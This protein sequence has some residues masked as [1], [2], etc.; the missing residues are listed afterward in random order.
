MAVAC[1]S[2]GAPADADARFCSRCGRTLAAGVATERRAIVTV[3]FCDLVEST[4]LGER[5]DPELLRE[6]QAQYFSACSVALQRHGGQIEK[7]I[8]DAVLCV[9]GLPRVRED[10]ALRACRAALDLRNG[11]AELDDRLVAEWSVGLDVRIGI[12]TGEVVTGDL[13]RDQVLATGDAV[14]V[15]ARLEQAAGPGEI[16]LGAETHRLVA[17]RVVVDAVP[18]FPAKG[19]SEPVRAYR[20]HALRD[21]APDV[22][23]AGPFVG[24]A[25][26]LAR[27]E[28]ALAAATASRAARGLLLV[29][30]PGI[31]KTRL[32]AELA[33]TAPPEVTFVR[34]TCLPY[35]EG[36]T[37]WPLREILDQVDRRGV[38]VSD[39]LLR[40]VGRRPGPVSRDETFDA[41]VRLFEALAADRP[42]VA[43]FED[44][45]WAEPL[46]LELLDVLPGALAESPVVVVGTARPELAVRGA[47]EALEPLRLDALDA[48]DAAA[49]AEAHGLDPARRGPVVGAA[50]GNPLFLEQ[51]CAAGLT[52][53]LP[54]DLRALLDARLGSLGE[55]ERELVEVAAVVGRDFWI[56]ALQALV[57]E[58]AVADLVVSLRTLERLELVEEAGTT[59]GGPPT[60]LSNVFT[61]SGRWSFRHTL[62]Q[63]AAYRALTKTRRSTLHAR[64]A[65][66]LDESAGDVPGLDAVVAWHLEQAAHL[67]AELRPAD[68][69]ELAARAAA[70]LEDA[71][72]QA[73]ERDD[74]RAAAG[75]LSRAASLAVDR[76]DGT[77]PVEPSL[78]QGERIA[79]YVVETVAGRGGMGVVYRAR[80]E[81]LGR[82]V[83]LKVISP[84]FARDAG[85]RSRFKRESLIAAQ[86]EHPN[87]VPV[88]TAGEHGERLY[89]AMRYVVGTDLASLIEREGRLDPET[90]A[91]I[92]DQVAHALDAAHVRGLVHRD[93]KP[94]NVLL[95]RDGPRWRAFLT[96]FG[97]SVQDGG[98][99]TL[100]RT[101]QWVG[102][103]AYVA[104]EQVRGS[105]VDGRADVYALGGVLHHCLTGEV[106][107]PRTHEL[108]ALSAHLAEPPPRPSSIVPDLLPFDDV[109]AR[110][111]AKEPSRR[112][113]TAVELGRA[114]LAASHAD[115]RRAFAG[116]AMRRLRARR[117][118][119]TVAGAATLL[120]AAAIAV[121]AIAIVGTGGSP[122]ARTPARIQV[123]QEPDSLAV[124]GDQVWALT[125]NGGRLARIDPATGRVGSFPAPVDLGGLAYPDIESGFG[126]IWIAH[127]N[128][129]VGGVD[130]INPVTVQA[131]QHIPLPGATAIA[132]GRHDV[133][134]IGHA[135]PGQSAFVLARIDPQ[136]NRIVHSLR[137]GAQP[138]AVA[139]G[140]GAVWVADARRDAVYRVDAGGTRRVATIP[141]GAGPGRIVAGSGAVWVANLGDQTLS[142]I[143]PSTNRVIGAPV[144]LGKEIDDIALAGS[145]LWVASA[146]ATVVGLRAADGTVVTPP[147]STDA[148]PLALA[149]DGANVWVASVAADTVARVAPR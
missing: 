126:S 92:V 131:E 16:L 57:P 26:D 18:P 94:G 102:T 137:L 147:V 40:A 14:N 77:E 138:V 112:Y 146:D 20:L 133:W 83:A 81:R 38:D 106:P 56:E 9:F 136:R 53:G 29:G 144:S 74:P 88:Y 86:I 93:V 104:P 130:R 15:A 63:E 95:T 118:G 132:V 8:G 109:V 124:L 115:R 27:L 73:L 100:T 98:E 127:A 30:E 68:A 125:S 107:Y 76:A 32:V 4:K 142:R 22:N 35:G 5:V 51:L 89:I 96:D 139:E 61:A 110:A 120:A 11:I 85:F 141:V 117:S 58:R 105:T 67:R 123:Q 23:G 72:R 12:N 129:T 71:G 41:V 44:L 69:G 87:V 143:D 111:M 121:A 2:C 84:A 21:A 49:I 59:R 13:G 24:R 128:A 75:L 103:L 34:G 1:P 97:L 70:R 114:A 78:V 17:G 36:I 135:R 50:G 145:T 25:R 149:S 148:A 140:A 62:V 47:P 31:G 108:D 134:A 52:G 119:R 66:Y 7:F 99:G 90:A 33:R 43:V 116:V 48:A 3:L 55:D 79:N 6:I 45:H 91:A 60:G 101:G 65:S 42:V 10:D 37:F 64:L 113:A 80:D 54:P 122:A 82:A 46:L 19:K 28:E 39:H